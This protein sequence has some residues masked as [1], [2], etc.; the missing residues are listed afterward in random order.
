M[1]T[2]LFIGTLAL[3]LVASASLSAQ[4]P[5]V[6][7]QF[8][9][10]PTARVFGDKV[11]LYPSHDIIS[12]VEPERRWFSMA[13]YHVFSSEN[14]TQWKDEGMILS[15][16]NVPWGNPEGYSMWAP[17]C[18]EKGGKYYFYY[19]NA[20]KKGFGFQ[21][22]VAV[23]D[24][25]TGPFVPEQES[26]KGVSG[27][28]PCVLRASDG[29]SYIYWSGMG[30][31]GVKLADNML[32]TE[33]PS[34]R[35]DEDFPRGNGL[36]EGPFVF[37]R[38]GRFYLTYPWVQDKTECL[39]YGMSDSP[40][41]PF[42][43]TGIIMEESQSGCWTN[44]HSI[45]QYKG[46]WYLFYHHNDL[47]PS[48]DKNRSVRADKLRFNSDGTI[49]QVTPTLRGVG[50]TSARSEIQL[51]RY[52]QIL[53]VGTGIDFLDPGNTF[54]GWFVSLKRPGTWV[55]YCDVD[56]S[57]NSPSSVTV[58]YRVSTA[59]T[60]DME[61]EE[62]KPFA[63]VKLP[64]AKKWS[65]ISAPLSGEVLGLQYICATLKEGSDLEIDWIKFE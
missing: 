6:R 19:P 34:Y 52:S 18:V 48:F 4:N 9:A 63:S 62:G 26:M 37:E 65:E 40:L 56:F 39:A 13:D 27:I 29:S 58:R 7:D 47:S 49:Q 23:A 54:G 15:Q 22:G 28:D 17:D 14:L 21:V 42:K 30:L 32:Q 36:K 51:D 20:P 61:A 64:K 38:E 59:A 53:P 16:E 25:P 41:G 8:T 1:N 55:K 50:I 35:L 11:Y 60:L 46:Q 3:G 24:S 57:E 44:H 33:G 12:P 10:D 31:R 43:F 45:V 5:I 2:K